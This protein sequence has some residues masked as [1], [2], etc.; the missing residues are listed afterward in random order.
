[1]LNAGDISVHDNFFELG[2]HS[3]LATQVISRIRERLGS[4][5]PLRS[6][7]ESPTV[8]ELAQGLDQQRS[9]NAAE[10]PILKSAGIKPVVLPEDIEQLSEAELDA[11]LYQVLP[12][13]DREI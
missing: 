12:E 6:V 4:E 8:S 7:F 3:L 9:H 1:L 10:L 2:G 11:L 5:L 13:A